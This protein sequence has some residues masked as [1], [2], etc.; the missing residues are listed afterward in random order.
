ME[1][2]LNHY[3]LNSLK[4]IKEDLVLPTLDSISVS[5]ET[6]RQEDMKNLINTLQSEVIEGT[7]LCE[8]IETAWN[9]YSGTLSVDIYVRDLLEDLMLLILGKAK[10]LE[11]NVESGRTTNAPPMVNPLMGCGMVIGRDED[12]PAFLDMVKEYFKQ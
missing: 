2:K 3:L 7:P 1:K 10:M 9:R 6:E 12:L 5:A 8:A 11:Y 4:E